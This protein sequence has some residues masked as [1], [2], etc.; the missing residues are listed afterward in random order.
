MMDQCPVCSKPLH[1][2]SNCRYSC[3]SIPNH[4]TWFASEEDDFPVVFAFSFHYENEDKYE[5]YDYVICYDSI[6]PKQW[7][8]TTFRKLVMSH[9]LELEFNI[10]FSS[11]NELK[12]FVFSIHDGTNPHVLFL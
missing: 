4:F 5:R 3:R 8:E 11:I 9:E 1:E 7:T 12:E 10:S 2:I 6:D